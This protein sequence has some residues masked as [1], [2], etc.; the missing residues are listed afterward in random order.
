MIQYVHMAK[1]L[2]SE[3][4]NLKKIAYTIKPRVTTQI[5]NK[6]H[7]SKRRPGYTVIQ[8][9]SGC[10]ISR[11]LQLTWLV[12]L[13]VPGSSLGSCSLQTITIR[14]VLRLHWKQWPAALADQ[15]WSSWITSWLSTHILLPTQLAINWTAN[16]YRTVLGR[17]KQ[18]VLKNSSR[19]MPKVYW[20]HYK[21]FIILPFQLSNSENPL[22]KLCT[23]ITNKITTKMVI[24]LTMLYN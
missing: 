4:H 21:S 2:I 5:I 20:S 23:V 10:R 1:K 19:K 16:E 6:Q 3:V 9:C 15:P 18:V 24:R 11:V 12:N 17:W 7:G 8:L 13:E 14:S 22:T